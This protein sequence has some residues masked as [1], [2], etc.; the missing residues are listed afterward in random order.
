MSEVDPMDAAR[1][2]DGLWHFRLR[3]VERYVIGGALSLLLFLSSWVFHEVFARLD[4]SDQTQQKIVINQA[5]TNEQLHTLST[6]LSD[7]PGL[8]RQIAELQVQT[9]RNTQDI[10]DLQ[11]VKG[12]AR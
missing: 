12:L 1:T 3:P 5:V 2:D 6:Q 11:Q 8:T 9:A 4:A 10:R 7:V